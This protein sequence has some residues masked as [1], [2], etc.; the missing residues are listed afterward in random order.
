MSSLMGCCNLSR[1]GARLLLEHAAHPVCYEEPAPPIDGA[2][3]DGDHQQRPVESTRCPPAEQHQTGEQHDAVDGVGAGHERGVKGVGHLGDHGEADKG[4]QH[5]DRQVGDEWHRASVNWSLDEVT[6]HAA[7]ISSERSGTIS[8]SVSMC[9]S[10]AATLLEYS[11]LACS[12]IVAGR[13][14]GDAM[15]T[16]CRTT[17][18][19]GTVSSQLPPASP[20]R[21][22]TT[23]PDRIRRTASAVTSRGAGRPGTTAGGVPTCKP[24]I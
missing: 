19:P 11:S 24:Q 10:S 9:S 7:R 20:A 15:V 14:N 12:G 5:Q 23:L 18:S 21:S 1:R 3:G 13:F 4:G 17:V 8:P 6:Q 16:P 2:E 22:T